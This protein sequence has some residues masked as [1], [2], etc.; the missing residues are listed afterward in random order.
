[1]AEEKISE[2]SGF[3]GKKSTSVFVPS[4]E[5]K[6]KEQI[7]ISEKGFEFGKNY[8]EMFRRFWPKLYILE[9]LH[10]KSSTTSHFFSCVSFGFN[11]TSAAVTGEARGSISFQSR[12]RRV[13]A[14]D[15][16][17]RKP[18]RSPFI[19]P[20]AFCQLWKIWEQA[21]PQRIQSMKEGVRGRRL[22]FS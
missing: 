9:L 1:M 2:P 13:P 21:R 19:K 11:T 7:I 17:D 16:G 5:E 18:I 3:V 14:I 8:H 20:S 6:A 15:R 22:L 10:T 4:F 12:R